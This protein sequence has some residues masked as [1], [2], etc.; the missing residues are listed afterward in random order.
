MTGEKKQEYTLRITR[1]NKSELVVILYDMFLTYLS[2]A[3]E[4]VTANPLD[5]HRSIQNARGCLCELIES[6]HMEYEPALNIYQIYRFVERELIKADIKREAT[7]LPP[8]KKIMTKW[9]DT[10]ALISA[11]D[12]SAPLMEH[13]ETVYAGMTY[14]KKEILETNPD[15]GSNRGFLC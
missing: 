10:Y 12:N 3:E 9:R 13:T 14:G 11:E 8:V 15:A 6:L 1:A 7:P 4:N 2:E 5:F